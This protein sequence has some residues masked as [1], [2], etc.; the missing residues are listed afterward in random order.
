MKDQLNRGK[1]VEL[2]GKEVHTVAG[3]LKLWFR[4]LP[5]PLLLFDMYEEWIKTASMAKILFFFFLVLC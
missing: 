3:L 4:Q 1:Q 5:D 2:E